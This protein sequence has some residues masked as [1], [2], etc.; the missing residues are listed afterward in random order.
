[1]CFIYHSLHGLY[2]SNSSKQRHI[3]RLSEKDCVVLSGS[4]SNTDFILKTFN[5]LWNLQQHTTTTVL[6]QHVTL[7]ELIH[8]LDLKLG[9]PTFIYSKNT[10][11]YQKL[12]RSCEVLTM[13]IFGICTK[14][15]R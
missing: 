9:M 11:G 6:Q 13:T 5:H 7:I 2:Q 10:K 3:V 8:A 12:K 15:T 14:A 1:M 4:N